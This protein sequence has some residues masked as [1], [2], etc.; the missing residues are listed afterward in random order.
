MLRYAT[1]NKEQEQMDRL[2]VT[3]PEAAKLL[4]VS[5]MTAYAAVREGAIPSLKI[6]RRVLVP[7]AALE[8]L[9][10]G[11]GAPPKRR[12]GDGDPNA[13]GHRDPASGSRRMRRRA[14]KEERRLA[15]DQAALRVLL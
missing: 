2:T 13:S 8:R 15:R 6:G 14:P 7:R 4:G 3:V 11:A 9:L 12:R 5:R 10:N 1:R